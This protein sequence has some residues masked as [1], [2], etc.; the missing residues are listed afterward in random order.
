[1]SF[2]WCVCRNLWQPLR[3]LS[4][5]QE[6]ADAENAAP[7]ESLS[8]YVSVAVLLPCRPPCVKGL[9]TVGIAKT[10]LAPPQRQRKASSSPPDLSNDRMNETRIEIS[11]DS[12]QFSPEKGPYANREE[13]E[14]SNSSGRRCIADSAT[15]IPAHYSPKEAP[16]T[17]R[18]RDL[19]VK[20]VRLFTPVTAPMTLRAHPLTA[21]SQDRHTSHELSAG[22]DEFVLLSELYEIECETTKPVECG[23]AILDPSEILC[24][25]QLIGH[26]ASSQVRHSVKKAGR[27]AAIRCLLGV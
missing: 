27:Q 22:D 8:A 19:N 1:M 18:V 12:T 4:L 21:N 13:T 2:L 15:D 14:T 11:W 6:T 25:R 16:E 10:I 26:G 7:Q 3:K 20:D 5:K 24:S 9:S 17:V 23:C